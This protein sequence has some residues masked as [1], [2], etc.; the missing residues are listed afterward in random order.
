MMV[1]I[2]IVCVLC[3]GDGSTQALEQGG[4]SSGGGNG[5]VF[6]GYFREPVWEGLRGVLAMREI[7]TNL[8]CLGGDSRQ[9]Q[10]FAGDG[11]STIGRLV[12][13]GVVNRRDSAC[14]AHFGGQAAS[15]DAC[16][17]LT[18][19]QAFCRRK[20]SMWSVNHCSTEM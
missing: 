11:I 13:F 15:V 7:S 19:Q 9:N 17:P 4:D 10:G 12:C 3:L 16:S 20:P 6:E 2:V 18:R 8:E 1:E 5:R 14:A